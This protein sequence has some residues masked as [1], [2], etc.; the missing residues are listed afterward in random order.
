[1]QPREQDCF[2]RRLLNE[3]GE[4]VFHIGFEVP[5]VDAAEAEG[6]ADDLRV[7]MRGR[8]SNGR[9]FTYFDIADQAGGV[10]PLG[11]ATP[12]GIKT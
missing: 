12:A 9:G 3:K 2:Q 6:V 11:R 4:G 10:T 7:K 5:D 8:R 1:M